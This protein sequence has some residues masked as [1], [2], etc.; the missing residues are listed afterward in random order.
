MNFVRLFKKAHEENVK[1]ADL[2]KK[3]AAKDK[4]VKKGTGLSLTRK[5]VD[6]S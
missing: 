5:V 1:Q 3:E 2:E 4:K 6:Y